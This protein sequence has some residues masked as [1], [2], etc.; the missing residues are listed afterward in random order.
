VRTGQLALDSVPLVDGAGVVVVPELDP[1]VLV[2]E[3]VVD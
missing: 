3:G 2:P 1:E